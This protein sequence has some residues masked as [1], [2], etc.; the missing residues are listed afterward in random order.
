MLKILFLTLIS[1]I[2]FYCNASEL[3]IDANTN[4]YDILPHA[5]IFIDKSKS[6]DIKDI[7]QNSKSKQIFKP[8]NQKSLSFGYSPDFDVWIRF[9]LKNNSNQ[10]IHKIIEYAN[11]MTTEVVFYD[12]DRKI[13]DGLLHIKSSRNSI[14]PIFKI[15][16]KP[17]ESRT[18]YIK[19]SS[20]ITTL[21]VKLR[22]C[23]YD[24]FYKREIKHQFILALFFGAMSILAIY[25][26]FIF[27][28]TR[29]ISYL[30]YV[31]YIIGISTHHLLYVGIAH[32]YLVKSQWLI[33]TVNYAS[34]FSV[35]PIIA[36]A[37]FTKTF[38]NTKQYPL[39][40]RLLTKF[41]VLVPIITVLFIITDDFNKFRNL[42]P[43]LLLLYLVGITFY[44]VIRRNHQAYFILFGWIVFLSAGL[45]MYLSSIGVFDIYQYFRYY[46]ETSLLLEAIIFSIALADRIKQLQK[47]KEDANHQLIVQKNNE[48][49]RLEIN[50][51]QKTKDLKIA[52]DE[53]ELLFRELNHRVKNNMQMIV[54][55]IRLQADEIEDPKLQD[56]FLTIQNRINAMGHL[57][58]LLYIQDKVTQINAYEYFTNLI[59]EVQNSYD[60][61][62]NIEFDIKT[63]LKITQSI[64]CGLILN[65]LITNSFKYAFEDKNSKNNN[66]KITLKKENDDHILLVQDNGIGYDLNQSSD[67]LGLILVQTLASEQLRGKLITDI[68]DGVKTTV[69]WNSSDADF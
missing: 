49:K 32:I 53:K 27:F 67:S 40:D 33:Y 47:E 25:N 6:V 19:A 34:L 29:D 43:L 15:T 13:K 9:S 41:I 51:A 46:I 36:L 35:F 57:H 69:I 8:I 26:L 65:E 28:F 58:K 60:E 5:T 63:D 38:L 18:Y 64:Y 62:I 56:M 11:S 14:N 30:Y 68:D 55:L 39:L 16:L 3:N 10:T 17:N 42:L 2:I 52:L 31:L 1:S 61:D 20:Y 54:S 21:I 23:N 66:I 37:L 48:T 22:L 44:S 59:D 7:I 4:A 50:V 12:K 24:D 45:F